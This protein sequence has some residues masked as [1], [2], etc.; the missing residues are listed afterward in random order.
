MLQWIMDN[1][2]GLIIPA[3]V[4]YC[5]IPKVRIIHCNIIHYTI[6]HCLIF[7]AEL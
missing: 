3:T 2:F 6:I 7:G 4:V 5:A 1:T